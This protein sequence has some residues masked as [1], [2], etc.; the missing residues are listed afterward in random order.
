M[1]CVVKVSSDSS[2]YAISSTVLRNQEHCVFICTL[3]R[4][5]F[6]YI[7]QNTRI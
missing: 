7:W 2:N 3:F 1:V 4:V 5:I 6:L